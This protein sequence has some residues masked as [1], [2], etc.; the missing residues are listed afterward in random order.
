M[1]QKA[2]AMCEYSASHMLSLNPTKTQVLWAGT[3]RSHD[4][5]IGD[6][7]IE[8]VKVI[9]VLGM[10]FDTKLRPT[11]YIESQITAAKTIKGTINRLALYLP[12]G[13]LLKTVARSLVMG[14]IGY[15]AAATY[16]LRFT[17]E[18]SVDP[19]MKS[20]QILINDVARLSTGIKRT[21]HTRIEDLLNRAGMTS[22][23]RLTAQAIAIETWRAITGINGPNDPLSEVLGQPGK[24][25]RITRSATQ[26]HL[27]PP[28]PL[29][30]QT[31]VWTAYKMWNEHKELREAKTLAMAKKTAHKISLQF[32][33]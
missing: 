22:I 10:K 1:E 11:P 3:D 32:P 19:G 33:V 21:S 23:N 29:S 4:L 26:E 13:D 31:F 9:E 15:G 5:S 18:D 17:N 16:P 6:T 2:A 12:R 30:A 24:M 28:L 25:A 27:P 8:P 7:V 14:K 20:I